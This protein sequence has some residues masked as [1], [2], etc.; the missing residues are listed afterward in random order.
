MAKFRSNIVT[1]TWDE[2]QP[3]VSAEVWYLTEGEWD[4][5]ELAIAWV[6]GYHEESS[7]GAYGSTV[8][9]IT[10][11]ETKSKGQDVRDIKSAMESL[12]TNSRYDTGEDLYD[13]DCPYFKRNGIE[14]S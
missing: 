2:P 12:A 1:W 14:R 3:G 7:A 13:M 9:E 8:A 5:V 6:M 10:L 4:E 11:H